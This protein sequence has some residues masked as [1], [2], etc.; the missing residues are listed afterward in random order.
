M[1][2]IRNRN[3]ATFTSENG[4]T[5]L[6]IAW[7]SVRGYYKIMSTKAWTVTIVQSSLCNI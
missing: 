6:I 2:Y 3:T 4:D 7:P 5:G 1:P